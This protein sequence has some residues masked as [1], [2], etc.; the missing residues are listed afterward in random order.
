MPN[1]KTKITPSSGNIFADI[2]LPGAAEHA[3]K[4]DVVIKLAKLIEMKKLSQSKAAAITGIAQPDLS[5]LLRGHIAGFSLDRLLQ[6]FMAL[7]TDVEIRL[8]KPVSNRRGQGRVL[9]DDL[10]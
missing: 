3:L 7:G 9:A 6:A 1:T 10:V 2:G 5:K 4:A 8:K